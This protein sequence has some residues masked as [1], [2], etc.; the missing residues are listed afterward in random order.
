MHNLKSWSSRG[1]WEKIFF[2]IKSPPNS[3]KNYLTDSVRNVLRH[4]I[5]WKY[6]LCMLKSC[7]PFSPSLS[8][9]YYH[10]NKLQVTTKEIIIKKWNYR[11]LWD[12]FAIICNKI[13]N[14]DI[15]FLESFECSNVRND[16][17]LK[18][19]QVILDWASLTHTLPLV[20]LLVYFLAPF[21]SMIIVLLQH[22][23]EGHRP[24]PWN[25]WL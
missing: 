10:E 23:C 1:S 3:I 17:T 4:I 24:V 22:H 5:V 16:K 2:S 6:Y 19:C 18:R 8:E 15:A 20:P 11:I 7:L 9:C 21:P 25:C 14:K 12:K 13:C